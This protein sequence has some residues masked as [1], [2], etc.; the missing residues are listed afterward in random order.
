MAGDGEVLS[1]KLLAV[2]LSTGSQG[3]SMKDEQRSA[4]KKQ[5]MALMQAGQPWQEA[6]RIAGVQTSRS[7][8]YR[9]FQQF[10]TQG[11]A[12]LHDGRHRHITKMRKPIRE[13]LEARCR[14]EPNL[15]SSS[16]QQEL[17]AHFGVLVSITHLNRICAAQGL[18]RQP[19][20]MG[21]K[22]RPKLNI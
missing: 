15:P 19:A 2:P 22:S 16:L 12:A 1:V 13:W 11:E 18:E 10:R 6:A 5:M 3:R 21:K 9:W 4:A 14:Q 8:A 17:N 20:R 7:T